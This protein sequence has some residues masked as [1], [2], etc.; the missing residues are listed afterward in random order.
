MARH[1]AKCPLTKPES[2]CVYEPGHCL[3]CR[4]A[5][6][7]AVAFNLRRIAVGLRPFPWCLSCLHYEPAGW[8]DPAEQFIKWCQ[9]QDGRL[10]DAVKAAAAELERDP[11]AYY[12]KNVEKHRPRPT[13][14]ATKTEK[15]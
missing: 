10:A 14:P 1:K 13:A 8:F 3:K 4:K 15:E 12:K 2:P 5:Q 9:Q 11:A 6:L 7:Q